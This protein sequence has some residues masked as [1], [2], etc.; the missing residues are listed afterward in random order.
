MTVRVHPPDDDKKQGVTVTQIKEEVDDPDLV[1]VKEEIIQEAQ[2][3]KCKYVVVEMPESGGYEQVI[4][5][6]VSCNILPCFRHSSLGVVC[7]CF[8]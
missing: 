5:P 8:H 7:Q 2:A 1:Q 3:K 4:G 6:E